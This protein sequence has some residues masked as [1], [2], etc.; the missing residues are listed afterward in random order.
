MKI[1]KIKIKKNYIAYSH[2][3]RKK[4]NNKDGLVFL[5]GFMSDMEGEKAKFLE[6]KCKMSGREFL[7]FDYSG[8]GQSSGSFDEGTIGRWLHDSITIINEITIGPQILVGSSMGGWLAFLVARKNQSKISAIIGI[9]TAPD[10]TEDMWK[11]KLSSK[12][13]SQIN[14]EGKILIP[15][16]YG[17]SNYIFTK[18]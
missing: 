2:I 10:F 14:K 9:S 8:H 4:S 11:H 18:K 17:D 16:N 7:R 12:E 5:C 3:P 1:S 6:E 13:K 15:S